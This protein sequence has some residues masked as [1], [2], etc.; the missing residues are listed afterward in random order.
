MPFKTRTYGWSE[1][2]ARDLTALR[3]KHNIV[4]TLAWVLFCPGRHRAT[5]ITEHQN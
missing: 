3:L 5:H 2:R 4:P 1:T